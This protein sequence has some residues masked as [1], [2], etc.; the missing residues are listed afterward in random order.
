MNMLEFLKKLYKNVKDSN[1]MNIVVE[2]L[3]KAMCILLANLLKATQNFLQT[4]EFD[5]NQD[6]TS[7]TKLSKDIF[8]KESLKYSYLLI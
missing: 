1:N 2:Y 5:V 7:V 3:K 8:S 4:K 6:S